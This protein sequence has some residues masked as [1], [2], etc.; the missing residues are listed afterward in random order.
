MR[1]TDT[2]FNQF[3]VWMIAQREFKTIII[4]QQNST[5]M[6][7][8]TNSV[9]Y[10][11][12]MKDDMCWQR[13]QKTILKNWKEWMKSERKHWEWLKTI[14]QCDTLWMMNDTKTNFTKWMKRTEKKLKTVI[15]SWKDYRNWYIESTSYQK[16][17][18]SVLFFYSDFSCISIFP[19]ADSI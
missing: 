14:Q 11:H 12:F 10:Q 13:L 1:H 15:L 4:E 3:E 18:T 17:T 5:Y 6:T 8:N 19:F 16:S 7:W 2:Q 9:K